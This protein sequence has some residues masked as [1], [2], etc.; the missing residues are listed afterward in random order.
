[1]HRAERSDKER[2]GHGPDAGRIARSGAGSGFVD[3]RPEASAQRQVVR[4]I[5]DSPF[6]VAQRRRLGGAVGSGAAVLQAKGIRDPVGAWNTL[7]NP[8]W[9][10]NAEVEVEGKSGKGGWVDATPVRDDVAA[11]TNIGSGEKSEFVDRRMVKGTAIDP[12]QV[13]PRLW[14]PGVTEADLQEM[15]VPQAAQVRPMGSAPRN[16]LK[17]ALHESWHHAKDVLLAAEPARNKTA[18]ELLMAKL[19]EFRQWHHEA[20]LRQT[21]ADA[22]IGKEGLSDWKAA[23]STTLTSDIDVN[24]KGSRTELAV[25]VFNR[26][27]RADGWAHEAGVVYDVNVYAMDFMH[28]DTFKGLTETRGGTVKPH[29]F[30]PDDTATRVSAKEGPREGS[31]G[32]GIGKRNP[33]LDERMLAADADLQRVWSLVKMRLY[34]TGGQWA[35]YLVNAGVPPQT[36]AAVDLR[37]RAYMDQLSER[38]LRG[39]EAVA[40][41]DEVRQTGFAAIDTVARAQGERT[42]ADPEQ[43]KMEASNRLYEEKLLQMA[44]LRRAVQT[45]IAL[46]Q[47]WLTAGRE[48]DAEALDAAID[49]NLAMLR[50]LI[51]ECAMLSNEAYVTDGAVNHTVVG[52]QSKIGITQTNAETMDAFNENVADSLKEIA[53]H[54]GSIGEAAYKAGKYLWRMAD[55]AR[56][57]D[58]PVPGID[59]LYEVGYTVANEIKGGEGGQADLERRAGKVLTDALGDDAATPAALM[60]YVRR[61]AAQVAHAHSAILAG[62]GGSRAKVVKP[63]R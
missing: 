48:D 55:A 56:N 44:G 46:R 61:T 51:S 50:D 16:I 3:N 17:H 35:E 57:L 31:Q 24:L 9:D 40:L 26:L 15:T 62:L 28:G 19:W 43:V 10:P 14:S 27:F 39:R 32:G 45:Q 58:S 12:G 29:K 4:D 1:M 37:Y 7:A 30:G 52:L 22:S 6:M 18:R 63:T 54:G 38:M 23:G 49:G 11:R 60:A 47:T 41:A 5:D 59:R 13:N 21:Q 2:R 42:R 34:M 8:T 20:I 33:V 36:T 25:G 53:R